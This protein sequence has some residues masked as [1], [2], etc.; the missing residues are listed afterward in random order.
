MWCLRT[1]KYFAKVV[2]T[3]KHY[4][5]V[6]SRSSARK[7]DTVS[8]PARGNDIICGASNTVSDANSTERNFTCLALSLTGS[9]VLNLFKIFSFLLL[10]RLNK[11]G[12]N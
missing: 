8:V 10:L 9:L 11:Y 5:C 12:L 1:V 6:V 4:R 3:K 2:V 7:Q